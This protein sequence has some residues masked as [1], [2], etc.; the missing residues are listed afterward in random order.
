M[1]SIW[2]RST[3]MNISR[4][5]GKYLVHSTTSILQNIFHLIRL[6]SRKTKVQEPFISQYNPLSHLR[7][8]ELS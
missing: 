5:A 7:R 8:S 1:P 3:S 4:T 6:H 2:F